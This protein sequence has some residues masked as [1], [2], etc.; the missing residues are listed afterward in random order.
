MTLC[1]LD[2]AMGNLS[3]IY[4]DLGLHQDALVMGEK[5]L[6]FRRRVLPE[7]HPDISATLCVVCRFMWR[8]TPSLSGDSMCN[9]AKT[10]I[11]LGR[12]QDALVMHEKVLEFRRR[13]LPENHPE[14]GV[15]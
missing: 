7:D 3:I 14:I 6:E 9:L 12:Y 10:F 5:S 8:L 11:S 2:G 4:S 13:V 15:T 1:S